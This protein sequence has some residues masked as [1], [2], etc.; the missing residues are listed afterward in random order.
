MERTAVEARPCD[1]LMCPP[2]HFAVVYAINPWMHPEEPADAGAALAEWEQ[3][4]SAYVQA[5]HNVRTVNPALGLPDMVFAANS[6]LVIDG[7]AFLARF[8]Y[9]QR[10]GEERLYGRWFKQHGYRV[11]R[12]EHGHEG[13]GDFACVGELILAGTGFRTELA[14]HREVEC[15]F[16]RPVLSLE[17]VDPRFYH[18]DTALFVLDAEQIAYFPDAFSA[19]GRATLRRRFPDAI[20]VGEHDALAFG[21]NAMSDGS[22]VFV[23]ASADQLACDLEG[24]GFVPVPIALPELRKAGGSVKCCTLELR[25]AS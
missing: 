6:A 25:S 17:L 8:R 4:R 20:I 14:A 11:V 2:A 15:V 3:L 9:P 1:L 22:N 18:L 23:P 19:D 7:I 21:C 12:A 13:E 24:R 5:G 16:K 10:R